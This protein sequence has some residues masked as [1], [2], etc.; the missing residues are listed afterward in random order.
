LAD[1]VVRLGA[2]LYERSPVGTIKPGQG[3]LAD[4]VLG[5]DSE[6]ARLPWVAHR[7]PKWE[8]EPLRWLGV[9]A[10]L[11]ATHLADRAEGRGGRPSPLAR[12]MG[13]LFG[14]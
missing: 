14:H 7:W 9:R 11:R 1:A 13:R 4:L 2:R 12:Y 6:I 10:A 5:H 3:T 8:P